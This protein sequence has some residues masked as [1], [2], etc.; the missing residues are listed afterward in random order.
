MFE[1]VAPG[2][3]EADAAYSAF[4]ACRKGSGH[5][6]GLNFGDAFSFALAKMQGLPLL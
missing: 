4:V 1:L 5:P 6:A 2:Q 3:L